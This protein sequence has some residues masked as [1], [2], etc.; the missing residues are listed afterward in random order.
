MFGPIKAILFDFAYTLYDFD[1]HSFY[2]GVPELVKELHLQGYYL[3]IVSSMESALMG[4]L[5]QK[6]NLLEF[7]EGNIV[8]AREVSFM[9]PHPEGVEK[10]LD[11]CDALFEE[12]LMVGD[13]PADWQAARAAGVKAAAA[14]WG[15]LLSEK[16]LSKRR[17]YKEIWESIEPDAVDLRLESPFSLQEWLVKKI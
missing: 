2:L 14:L 4:D 3:G 16:G 6:E 9:K 5:L 11:A 17:V 15:R 10:A 12:V 7:F 1:N 13:S 8:G